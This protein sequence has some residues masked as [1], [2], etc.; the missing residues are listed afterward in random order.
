MRPDVRVIGAGVIGLSCAVRLAEAGFP[1][2]VLAA[3]APGHTTSAVAGGLWLPYRAEPAEKVAR[4]AARTFEEFLRLHREGSRCVLLRDGLL[5]HR[6]RPKRPFWA[7]L[8]G[9][10]SG[11]REV[12]DPAPGFGFGY[13]LRVPVV[14][15]PRY[16]DE[17]AARLRELGGR[18]SATRLSALPPEGIVVNAAGLGAR[19][20]AGDPSVYAVRGQVVVLENPGLTDW[21]CDEDEVDGVVTYVLPRRDDVVVGGTA[22]ER[23]ERPDPDPA[24]AAGILERARAL[25]PALAGARVRAHRVGLRPARPAVRLA[26]DPSADRLLVHCYGHGGSGVTLSWGC[27]ADVLRLVLDAVQDG[28]TRASTRSVGA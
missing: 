17:L 3:A 10:I 14:D 1:V 13:A 7:D 27:A 23:D 20:L 11:L 4:W 26:A 24:D 25:V 9:E 6:E 16:V 12:T 19:E 2:E 18:I 22:Q 21:I 28:P 5:L 15:T 8:V